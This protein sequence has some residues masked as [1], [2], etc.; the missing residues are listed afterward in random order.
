MRVKK[1]IKSFLP[2]PVLSFYHFSLAWLGALL[3]G[4]PSRKMMI[5]GVTGTS[6][7]STTVELIAQIFQKAGFKVASLS[8]INFRIGEKSWCND[9]KMTMPG[10]FYLQHFLARAWQARC[11]YVVLEVTSEGILQSRHRFIDFDVL[12]F[13]NLSPEHLERH[14]GFEN[15]KKT[16]GKLFQMLSKT[17]RQKAHQKIKKTIIVNLDDPAASYFLSFPADR[18]I[19]YSLKS[20]SQLKEVISPASLIVKKESAHFIIQGTKFHLFLPG[21]FNVSNA[22]AAIA[23]GYSQG[24][25]FSLMS[26][27]LAQVRKVPGRLEKVI[28]QPFQVFVDY[29]HTPVALEKVYQSLQPGQGKMICLLGSCGGGRDKWKRPVFGKIASRYCQKIIVTNEDPYDENPEEI[30]QAVAAGVEK[31]FP[32]DN[33]LMILDRRE[34]IQKALSL[35]RAGDVVI[36]TGKGS[37]SLMCLAD[38]KKIPWSDKEEVFKAMKQIT[39]L[40]PYKYQLENNQGG[41]NIPGHRRH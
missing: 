38:G 30:I 31:N 16:K 28:S 27:A 5:I 34:A 14:G 1:I 22:L 19:G 33:L 7:K 6:G 26:K 2:S 20:S 32:R 8:S 11:Q 23:V 10:R 25:G 39:A 41:D 29:A 18:W 9:L 17:R 21:R 37:E 15:Y 13:T 12:V 36:L 24:L 4:F 3:Y 35:A 40:S